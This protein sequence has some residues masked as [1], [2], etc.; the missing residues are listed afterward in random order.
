MSI[1]LR[2]S[3]LSLFSFLLA[4]SCEE[5]PVGIPDVETYAKN[6]QAYE[7]FFLSKAQWE[8]VLEKTQV[9]DSMPD[10]EGGMVF[11]V[12]PY[13]GGNDFGGAMLAFTCFSPDPCIECTPI[14]ELGQEG[15]GSKSPGYEPTKQIRD[16]QCLPKQTPE[17]TEPIDEGPPREDPKCKPRVQDVFPHLGCLSNGCVHQ[18][19][20]WL[21]RRR[22][23]S[24]A[25]VNL[26]WCR[27]E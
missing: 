23:P 8:G 11:Q 5:S 25:W 16:C 3:L 20:Y 7:A 27:C 2:L 26:L 12:M 18:C 9:V 17:C 22:L 21:N 15:I 6:P 19:G 10:T 13:V 4:I 1:A 24:G 14:G